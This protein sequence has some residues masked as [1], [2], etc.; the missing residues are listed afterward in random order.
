[1]R[2]VFLLTITTQNAFN[3]TGHND[4]P[5]WINYFPSHYTDRTCSSG[6]QD[7]PNFPSSCRPG[8]SYFGLVRPLRVR[9][10][11][12]GRGVWEHAPALK[13]SQY[14]EN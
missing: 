14:L 6:C 3:W 8:A 12:Q 2:M 9:K 7:E 10:C 5:W 4:T 13:L 1:M 11:E